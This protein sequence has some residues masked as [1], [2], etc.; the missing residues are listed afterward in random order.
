M[1]LWT[2]ATVIAVPTTSW[3]IHINWSLKGIIQ[4]QYRWKK[5]SKYCSHNPIKPL[6]KWFNHL[7]SVTQVPQEFCDYKSTICFSTSLHFAIYSEL[8]N[9]TWKSLLNISNYTWAARWSAICKDYFRR[10]SH[11]TSQLRGTV[12]YSAWFFIRGI[13]IW[14]Q[15]AWFTLG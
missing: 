13:W 6:W 9:K 2:G 5:C 14:R 8:D 15:R 4:Q 10:Q 11:V 7:S 1:Y 12:Q 3:S